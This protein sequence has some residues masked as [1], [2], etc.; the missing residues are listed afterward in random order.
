MHTP[1]TK[2][3]VVTLDEIIKATEVVA[4]FSGLEFYLSLEVH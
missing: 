1:M 2:V 3:K 4:E